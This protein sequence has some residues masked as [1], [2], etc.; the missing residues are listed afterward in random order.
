MNSIEGE[1]MVNSMNFLKKNRFEMRIGFG[2]E[3]MV[4]RLHPFI[5]HNSK[6]GK[7]V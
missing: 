2:G 4:L 1:D 6:S 3:V 7:K 5:S